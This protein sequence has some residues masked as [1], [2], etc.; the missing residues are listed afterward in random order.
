VNT[1]RLAG[2]T[3]VQSFMAP[4]TIDLTAQKIKVP[5]KGEGKD[6]NVYDSNIRRKGSS[7]QPE[8]TPDTQRVM[9]ALV[10]IN[11]A[12]AWTMFDTGSTADCIAP[13]FARV[14][15]CKTF[16]LESPVPLQLG[17]KGSKSTIT[18]GTNVEI[19]PSDSLRTV[20]YMDIINIDRY[21]AILGTPFMS[22][23]GVVLNLRER[24]ISFAEGSK[25]KAL[26]SEEEAKYRGVSTHLPKPPLKGTPLPKLVETAKKN[27]E[28]RVSENT[29][30]A[31]NGGSSKPSKSRRAPD[32]SREN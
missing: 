6:P 5:Y 1:V 28:R 19:S 13:E 10:L 21:D 16:D 25:I 14:N 7:A 32:K 30:A 18:Y 22:K 26:S 3:V 29:N 15:K 31:T 11:G 9:T 23:H 12:P 24:T 27:T 20:E 17:T 8:R 2:M 4:M